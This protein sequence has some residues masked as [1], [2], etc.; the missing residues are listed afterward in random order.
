MIY[1]NLKSCLDDLERTR[2]LVRI[3]EPIDPYIE[4]GAIQRRV[5]QAGGPALLFT[6]VKGTKFPMAANIFGT[7]ARTKFIFRATLR[8]VEAMLSAKADPALVLKKPGLW[9]GL[10]LGAWH[11]LPRT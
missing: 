8:R 2:Q 4:A 1:R 5:F 10:A 6:N 11:T 9:P 3:D 7:L